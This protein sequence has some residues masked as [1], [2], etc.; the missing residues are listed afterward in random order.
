MNY[1][2]TILLAFF[3]IFLGSNLSYASATLGTIDPANLGSYKAQVQNISLGTA[4]NINFGKFTTASAKNI[5]I[6][7]TELR[8]FAWGDGV[9]WIVTNCADTTSGCSATNGNFKVS[10]NG[11]GLLSGYAWGENTGWINFGPFTNTSISQVKITSGTFGGSLGA[12]G[13]AWTQN[14]GWIVFDCSVVSSCVKT[15]WGVTTGGGGG[16]GGTIPECRDGRDNDSDGLIDYPADPGCTDREDNTELTTTTPVFYQ[17]NDGLDNDSDGLIDFPIDP[18]CSSAVDNSELNIIVPTLYQCNDNIDNDG[19]GL[20]DYPADPGCVSRLDNDE[21]NRVIN[22]VCGPLHPELCIPDPVCSPQRPD[23][24]PK[25]DPCVLNPTSCV[26]PPSCAT[27]PSLC[28]PDL[29]FCQKNPNACTVKPPKIDTPNPV[30]II[31]NLSINK[32]GNV[33]KILG[34]G[35]VGTASL[36]S[37]LIANP[38]SIVDLF[39]IIARFWSLVLIAFGIKKKGNPWGTVYNSVTKQPIDPA[40]VVLMDMQ[41][42]EIASC[43]T[44]IDGRYGFAVPAGSYTI[45]VNKTNHEFPSKKLANKTNDELYEDLY[46]GGEIVVSEDGGII[47]KNIPLDQIGFDWNEYAK[48]EQNRL[49]SYKKKNLLALRISNILFVT[50]FVVTGISVFINPSNFNIVVAALYVVM[51]IARVIGFRL[52][53]KGSVATNTNQPLPFSIVRVLSKETGREIAHK[54]ADSRGDYYALLANGDY[55]I[56]VDKKNA[57]ESYTT[58]PLDQS[59]LVKEGYM[60]DHF[61]L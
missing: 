29:T 6:S 48:N 9:G 21:F 56:V 47:D 45:M 1:L 50:G 31:K 15:D 39:L 60:K 13:Y 3:L 12:A 7:N 40:Y 55:K 51:G 41:G 43:I 19:D 17:C 16:G 36:T 32:I 4:T 58:V 59:V 20:I 30:Q 14:F 22:P 27:N 25:I 18:G 8:G 24:C 37:F 26:P 5:T 57:D 49:H 52:H 11:S 53:P 28:K 38:F 34:L 2:K 46:F 61:K 33:A 54:V 42:N 10:N 35:A 23:L 44:D